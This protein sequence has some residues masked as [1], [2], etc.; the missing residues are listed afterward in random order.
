MMKRMRFLFSLAAVFCAFSA[1][2]APTSRPKK[3]GA[4]H[5]RKNVRKA[6]RT[7]TTGSRM[8]I[9]PSLEGE[10]V[11]EHFD[12]IRVSEERLDR[13]CWIDGPADESNF[14]E[15]CMYRIKKNFLGEDVLGIICPA[16]Q[17]K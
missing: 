4:V 14:R 11:I 3:P 7:A 8:I 2:A 10:P 9:V 12:S 13:A 1:A 6:T 17:K 16:H 15:G 5:A